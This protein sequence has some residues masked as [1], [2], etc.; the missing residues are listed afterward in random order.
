MAEPPLLL[1]GLTSSGDPGPH[2]RRPRV[3]RR[4]RVLV[5][6]LVLVVVGAILTGG[7]LVAARALTRTPAKDFAGPGT[8]QV[9]VQVHDGDS[10]TMIGASLT[11]AGVVASVAAFRQAADSDPKAT[12]IQAGFYRL[13]LG[14]SV[15][16]ALSALEDPAGLLRSRVS[17]PEGTSLKTL[18]PLLAKDTEV[19]LADLEAAAK[20]PAALGLPAYAQGQLEGFLFPATYDVPPGTSAVQLLRLLTA[21]F[22]QAATDVDLVDGAARLGRT[23]L[24][25]V[26]IASIIERESAAPKDAASVAAVFYNRL[27]AG[28]PLGSEF[29]VAYT[30]NDPASPYN[31]YTHKGFP[32][33]PYDSP[34]EATLKAALHPANIDALFFVTLPKEGTLFVRTDAQFNAL[35]DRCHAEGGCR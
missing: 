17:V 22:A 15:R 6:V 31:T 30:G 20:T 23:P 34:G 10:L 32:P 1:G 21:R 35:V 2:P 13:R 3:S 19:P 9:V 29:T 33:G 4:G 8:G 24:Q 25:I 14:M 11:R 7:A 12:S 18:L 28:L 5:V 16:E 26:T 27:K